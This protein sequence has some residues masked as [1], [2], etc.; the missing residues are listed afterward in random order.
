MLKTN[1]SKLI[2]DAKS[3]G[4][5]PIMSTTGK[6]LRNFDCPKCNKA[7]VVFKNDNNYVLACP[8]CGHRE[9][10][11]GKKNEPQPE[12]QKQCTATTKKGERCKKSA[13]NGYTCSLHDP[14]ITN[15]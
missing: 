15:Y 3:H 11:A 7:A 2:T 4:F 5:G 12:Q 8:F 6:S 1:I 10:R 9:K 13:I 14:S